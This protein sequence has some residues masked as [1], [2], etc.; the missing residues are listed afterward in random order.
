MENRQ[1][2]SNKTSS[3]PLVILAGGLGV[4]MGALTENVPKPMLEIHGRPMLL[5]I[6]CHYASFGVKEFHILA[7]YKSTYIKEYFANLSINIS[8]VRLSYH[9]EGKVDLAT[10]TGGPDFNDWTI[11]VHETGYNSKTGE[12]LKKIRSFLPQEFYFTYGDSLSNFDP[13]RGMCELRE[14][15]MTAVLCAVIKN[16]RF[17]SLSIDACNNVTEFQEK[18]SSNESWI[19]GGFMALSQEIFAFITGSND[20]FEE[21]VLPR[22]VK[23]GKLAAI[24][25]RDFWVALDHERELTLIN[26]SG[27]LPWQTIR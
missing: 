6:M 18:L 13:T 4:R 27:K 9:D 16:E 17:G 1:D 14:R 3:F 11:F 10:L 2:S 21:D 22:V 19:N 24:K 7:G 8:S 23:N 15:S 12:R 20:S 26:S 25:H 5:H